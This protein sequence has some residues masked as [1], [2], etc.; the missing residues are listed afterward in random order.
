M[1]EIQNTLQYGIKKNGHPFHCSPFAG[2][3]L[4]APK[5]EKKEGIERCR[6]RTLADGTE[7]CPG[8]LLATGV[9]WVVG[10]TSS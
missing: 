4:E 7:G 9:L 2:Q 10:Q 5:A 8:D 1:S 6:G 3:A